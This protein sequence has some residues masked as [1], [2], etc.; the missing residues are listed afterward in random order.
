MKKLI[1]GS[2]L[3]LTTGSAFADIVG[4]YAGGGVWGTELNGEIGETTE[5]AQP[6]D[7]DDLGVDA[8]ANTFFYVALEHPVPVI[9]NIKLMHSALKLEGETNNLAGTVVDLDPDS[10]EFIVPADGYVN[11]EVDFS[12]TDA[13]LY[14]EILDNYI[15]ID[16]GLTARALDGYARVSTHQDVEEVEFDGVVPM[17]Y[18]K[19]QFD[20]PFTGWYAGGHGNFLSIGDNEFTDLDVRIGYLT[21]G[22]GLDFGFDIGYRQMKLVVDES[23]EAKADIEVGGPYLSV[24]MH[25]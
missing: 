15:S 1:I 7:A 25:F 10:S 8:E 18:L 6:L 22:L 20:L 13:T 24:Q 16:L 9:P 2:T 14:Y 4:I 19:G 23:S 17:L 3:L 12:H 5:S 11:T 21:D